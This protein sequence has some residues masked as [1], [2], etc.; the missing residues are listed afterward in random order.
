MPARS[1]ASS[2]TCAVMNGSKCSREESKSRLVS[3]VVCQTC[4]IRFIYTR[5]HIYTDRGWLKDFNFRGFRLNC[6]MWDPGEGPR[7]RHGICMF[8]SP[9]RVTNL[10]TSLGAA[11]AGSSSRSGS[12]Q[13]HYP[14]NR[15]IIIRV[16]ASDRRQQLTVKAAENVA[17]ELPLDWVCVHLQ[18]FALQRQHENAPAL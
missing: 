4:G 16:P 7:G 11:G 13:G 6:G 12:S 8:F 18:R 17:E 2:I 15:A 1:R 14:D 3:R 9:K 10:Q 5:M